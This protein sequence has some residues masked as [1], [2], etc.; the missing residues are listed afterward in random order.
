MHRRN[1]LIGS[2]TLP[3]LGLSYSPALAAVDQAALKAAM[4]YGQQKGAGSIRVV[5]NGTVI[6][7]SGDQSANYQLKS[8]TKFLGGIILVKSFDRVALSA[9][10]INLFPDFANQPTDSN[11][12]ARRSLVTIEQLAT[13]TAGF[14]GGSPGYVSIV[15]KPGSGFLYSNSGYNWLADT[16]T[17]VYRQD[18][19]QR[20]RNITGI[21]VSWRSNA[22][23]STTL[24]SVPRR[25]FA[26]GVT[27]SVTTMARIGQ[28]ALG[29]N[30]SYFNIVR[31]SLRGRPV[32]SSNT[33]NASSHYGLGTW[34][35]ADGSISG[36]PKDAYWGWGLGDTI[37]L[38][39]PS[40]KLV[41]T[42][43]GAAWQSGW[44]A[45]YSVVAPFFQKIVAAVS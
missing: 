44:S 24:Y 32:Y 37:I 12:K 31:A 1:L 30:Q 2:L 4:D 26:S 45:R 22:Y 27:T 11:T 18:M 38:V 9:K 29:L 34:N 16:L 36:V 35:N 25:E 15:K 6:G 3:V 21:G 7:T 13:H 33:P 14:D 19:A 39:I 20:F 40:L 8:A 17:Y 41:V 23:R 10:A 43:G 28:F 42:R 5:Q